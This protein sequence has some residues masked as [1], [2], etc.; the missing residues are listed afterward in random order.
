M[1]A[2]KTY[3]PKR[4]SQEG[5]RLVD[6]LNER[7]RVAGMKP[8]HLWAI[9]CDWNKLKTWAKRLGYRGKL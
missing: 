2:G 6:F 9:D 7:F 5:I 1:D 4:I 8:W 3:S